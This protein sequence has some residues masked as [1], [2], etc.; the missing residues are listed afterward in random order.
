MQLTTGERIIAGSGLE[1]IARKVVSGERLSFKDGCA[2]YRGN[3]HALGWLANLV[4]ERLHGKLAFFICNQHINYSNIC[5][6][7]CTFCAFGK[8]P[9]QE[10]AYE[11]SI[12]EISRKV[13]E[14]LSDPITELHIVGGCHPSLPLEYY[15]EML[16]TVKKL[17]PNCHIQGFTCVEIAHFA[18]LYGMAVEDVLAAFKEAG[19]GSIPGGGAEVFSSRVRRALCP[20]KL[21]PVRWLDVA[22]KAHLM[23]LKTNATMLYGHIETVEERVEHLITLREL[24]D[25]TRGFLTFIPLA[26][27]PEN[28]RLAH[29]PPPTGLD[30]LRTTAV[31]RLILDNFHH[32]KSFWIMSSPKIA[33]ISLHFGADDI[34][35]TIIEEKITHMA[36]A[37]T[38]ENMPKEE[39][40]WLIREAGRTPVERDTLYEELKEYSVA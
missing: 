30:E 23:G 39:L 8:E 6:N 38:A 17:R 7:G 4:R 40:I 12:E 10:G 36:G 9:G 19:L 20:R 18:Q 21:S 1:S 3:F 16:R 27:H 29:L 11:M 31:A 35:G 28:T 33:Q 2:L 13:Q 34:D 5:T 25:E 24:Q 22:R 15:L 14:R 26:F 32:I 37:K